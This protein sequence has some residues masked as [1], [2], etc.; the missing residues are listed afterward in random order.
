[1]V[2]GTF[3]FKNMENF[4]ISHELAIKK[5]QRVNGEFYIANNIN[6]LINL[7]YKVTF[8]EVDQWIN[9]GDFF[10]LNQYIYYKNFFFKNGELIK[11]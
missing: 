8:F 6:N 2:I 11:C 10:D 5:K 1:M 7:K 4:I 9:L 3:W